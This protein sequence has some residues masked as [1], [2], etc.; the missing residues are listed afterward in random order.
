VSIR[1]LVLVSEPHD[2]KLAGVRTG[3]S[4]KWV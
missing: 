4:G 1:M 3:A 2:D